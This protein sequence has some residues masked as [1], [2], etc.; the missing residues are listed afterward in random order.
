MKKRCSG[1]Q[2]WIKFKNNNHSL[3]SLHDCRASSDCKCKD[4]SAIPYKREKFKLED[5]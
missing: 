5:I 3:C 4:W 2:H 1:C